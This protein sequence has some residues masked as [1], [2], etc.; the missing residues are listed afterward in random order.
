MN[1]EGLA[2]RKHCSSEE[3]TEDDA[4]ELFSKMRTLSCKLHHNLILL[5]K[6]PDA[7]IY[8]QYNSWH[9]FYVKICMTRW[10]ELWGKQERLI[11]LPDDTWPHG[12]RRRKMQAILNGDFLFIRSRYLFCSFW[13]VK[14]A[15]CMWKAERHHRLIGESVQFA[16][17]RLKWLEHTTHP[18]LVLARMSRFSSP[19]WWKWSEYWALKRMLNPFPNL[20]YLLKHGQTSRGMKRAGPLHR[21]LCQSPQSCTL[22]TLTRT[23]SAECQ[24]SS[25]GLLTCIRMLYIHILIKI[26]RHA[27][28]RQCICL[29]FS[30]THTKITI[31][32]T[33]LFHWYG[34]N[35]S[36]YCISATLI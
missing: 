28:D 33:K 36:I 27:V 31:L 34:T 24:S 25:F 4:T 14:T 1:S 16:G 15:T 35:Y 5:L 11:A 29:L 13:Y 17:G 10:N 3:L 19:C 23:T 9:I 30:L 12:L 26:F 6:Y 22:P 20:S 2:Y 8:L 21:A 7:Q 18:G 32:Q